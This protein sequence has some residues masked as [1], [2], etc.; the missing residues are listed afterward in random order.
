VGDLEE[1][2]RV[3]LSAIVREH[4]A[5][6]GAAAVALGELDVTIGAA[7]FSQGH[8]CTAPVVTGEPALS[9]ERARFLP[10][11]AELAVAGRAYAPIDLDLRGV[12]VLTGPNMGGKSLA[13]QTCGFLALCTAFG[14]PSPAAR[15]RVGLFDQIAWLGTGLQERAGGL[16]SSFA[17][18]LMGLQE[19]LA[20]SA[21]RL[22][23][24]VDEFART[25]TPHEGKA[26]VVALTERLRQRNACA[27]VATHLQ[28]VAAAGGVA[29]FAVRGLKG[30]GMPPAARN[31]RE[32]LDALA[33]SMDY[34][35]AEV[36]N[37]DAPHA[38]AIA[39][40][41]L[42]GLDKQFV[43]AAYRALSQ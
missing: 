20:R 1:R 30:I 14:L 3:R 19:I 15:V 10:L 12:A 42:L 7:R 24:F 21:P 17:R 16:L 35:I 6:L 26:L 5:G 22:L 8:R 25:T 29:H 28:G 23:I 9:F 38:D 27:L 41:E 32:A 2:V 37:D 39:L 13:L 4:A 40:A 31:L 11:E 18:E 36:S 43:K 34:T 33:A